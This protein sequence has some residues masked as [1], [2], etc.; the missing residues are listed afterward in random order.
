MDLPLPLALANAPGVTEAERPGA[1]RLM[2]AANAQKVG[3]TALCAVLHVETQPATGIDR[4]ELLA[5]AARALA[6]A[7]LKGDALLL[8]AEAGVA[9]GL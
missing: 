6:L 7:G 9:G 5:E 1:T 2:A 8:A 4:A 3:E